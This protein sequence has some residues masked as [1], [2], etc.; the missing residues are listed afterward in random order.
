M[1]RKLLAYLED[2]EFTSAQVDIVPVTTQMLGPS[3]FYD[4]VFGF[5]QQHLKRYEDW[6]HETEATFKQLGNV[7]MKKG[8]FAS[9]NIFVAHGIVP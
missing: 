6:D 1:G 2:L 5:K 9:E 3:L 8:A 7:L 4:I